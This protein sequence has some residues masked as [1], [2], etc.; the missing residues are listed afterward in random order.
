MTDGRFDMLNELAFLQ[1]A[2]DEPS[3]SQGR[4]LLAGHPPIEA[5]TRAFNMG[6]HYG[7]TNTEKDTKRT[8]SDWLKMILWALAR[9]PDE[10][11]SVV[12]WLAFS[13]TDS[14]TE[15]GDAE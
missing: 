2:P 3:I 13:L 11:L 4:M 10:K 6:Y 1:P 14:N 15:W 9:V 7:R 5:V 12:Y 8:C